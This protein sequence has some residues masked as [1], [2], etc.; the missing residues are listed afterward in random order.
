MPRPIPPS[1]TRPSDDIRVKYVPAMPQNCRE[2]I[3]AV[4]RRSRP[5]TPRQRER[6]VGPN[7]NAGKLMRSVTLAP[8]R[9]RQYSA[10]VDLPTTQ[11][12]LREVSP[13]QL[14]KVT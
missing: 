1:A 7:S 10:S 4:S 12:A 3:M 14:E 11:S 8:W 13:E 9:I 2:L 6:A 5:E